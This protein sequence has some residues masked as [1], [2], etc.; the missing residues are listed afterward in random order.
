MKCQVCGSTM[1]PIVASLPF[2]LSDTAIVIVKE[3][4]V[5]QCGSCREFLIEDPV[6]ERLEAILNRADADTELE[7][8]RYAA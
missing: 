2:R 5:I 8:V 1:Q 6:M 7:I 4:P 3:L